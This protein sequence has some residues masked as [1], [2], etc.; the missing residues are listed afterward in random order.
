M[1]IENPTSCPHCGGE[2]GFHTKEIVDFKQLYDW[3]GTY[4]EGQHSRRI[5]GGKAFY[6]CDCGWNV[7]SRINKPGANQ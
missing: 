5:R 7:T 1:A 2:N 6:C 4:A 3:D